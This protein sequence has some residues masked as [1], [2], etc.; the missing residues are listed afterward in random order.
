MSW[1]GSESTNE[2]ANWDHDLTHA[3]TIYT[4][5][6][7]DVAAPFVEYPAASPNVMAVGGTTLTGCSGAS[8][9]G[10]VVEQAWGGSG[11]ISKYEPLPG[12]QSSHTGP[13]YSAASITAL[14]KGKRGEPA[15]SF[16]ADP[17]TGV[18]VYDS[19]RFN[20][21][22]GWTI[23]GGASLDALSW[24]GVLAAGAAAGRTAL[25]GDKA[26]TPAA[27][28]SSSATSPAAVTQVAAAPTA[29]Q[30]PASTC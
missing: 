21:Q 6:A 12:Y 22:V 5:A 11:G 18:S 13:V 30:A 4:V 10:F 17:G 24:A 26:S 27:T 29:P 20:G 8:C 7:G 19:A 23:D 28:R 25:P 2:A 14:T 3:G 9:A 15:V 1:G 16:D